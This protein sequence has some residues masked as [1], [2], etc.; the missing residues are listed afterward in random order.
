MEGHAKPYPEVVG[1]LVG[2]IVM[3]S[4]QKCPIAWMVATVFVPSP[5]D[6]VWIVT[7]LAAIFTLPFGPQAYELRPQSISFEFKFSSFC[8]CYL[9]QAGFTA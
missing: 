7:G 6:M 9:S 3:K 2:G 8:F 5:R 1:I 4:A